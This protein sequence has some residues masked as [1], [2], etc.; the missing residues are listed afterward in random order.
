[1]KS[2]DPLPMARRISLR[3][4][5]QDLVRRLEQTSG[6]RVRAAF[7]VDGALKDI[8]SL[9][10]TLAPHYANQTVTD[11]VNYGVVE[12]LV[13]TA[14]NGDYVPVLARSLIPN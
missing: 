14:D 5:Q 10:A 4:F 11:I 12:G 13:M 6:K 7:A 2:Y 1:M 8:Q 3:E 9:P